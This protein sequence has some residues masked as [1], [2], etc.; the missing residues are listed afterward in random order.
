MPGYLA[1]LPFTPDRFQVE[2]VAAIE[3]GKSVVVTAP[4]GSGKTVIAEAAVQMAVD[5]GGRAFYTTPIKALSNQKFGDLSERYGTAGVGLL[6]GD[7]SI[8]GD[9]PI[10][11]MT[12]EVLRNMIHARSDALAGLRIIILDE[13]HY[14]GDRTRGAVWEEVIIHA[15]PTAQLVC[16]SATIANPRQVSDW[17]A[18]RRGGVELVVE[19]HRPVPLEA[20]YAI[21]DRWRDDRVE[22][23]PLFAGER[24]NPAVQRRLA[25]KSGNARHGGRA[26]RRFVTPRR[27]ETVEALRAQGML[28][29]IY[30]IFSRKGCEHAAGSVAATAQRKPTSQVDAIHEVVDEH[31]R[32][33]TDADLAVLDHGQWISQLERGI[34]AH[35][36][37]MVPAF[38][39]AVE[40][41]FASNLLDVV[42]ATE[43]LA[44]GI[45]MPARAVVLDSLTKFTGD[46][47]ELLTPS[48]Y[49]QLT[50]RAGRRGI[51]EVGFGVVLHSPYIRFDKV[52]DLA[53]TGAS[54]LVSSFRPTYN[55]AVNLVANYDQAR[56]EELLRASFAQYQRAG[57]E[58]REPEKVTRLRAELAALTERVECERGSTWEYLAELEG[59]GPSR[60]ALDHLRPGDVLEIPKGRR[61]G[62]YVLLKRELGPEPRLG[63]LSAGGKDATLTLRDLEEGTTVLG[64]ITWR[65]P[66]RPRDKHFRQQTVQE[67]RRFRP[68]ETRLLHP[69]PVAGSMHPVVLCPDRDAHL[70]AT[71][72]F[73]EVEAALERAGASAH[74]SLVDEFRAVLRLLEGRGYLDGWSLEPAGSRLRRVYSEQDLLVSECLREG[75]FVPCDPPELAALV[76]AFVFE[77]RAEEVRDDFPN[78]HVAEVGERMMAT[79]RGI[80]ADERSLR[81]PETRPPEFGFAG[82]AYAWSQGAD[83]DDLMDRSP[84]PAGDFVRVARQLLDLLRQVRDAE[85]GLAATAGEAL[86]SIDRGIVT[87]GGLE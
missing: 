6:T 36:A 23:L 86:R 11:V 83:L 61:P 21:K 24:P 9:A 19:E 81:L 14:L 16:L 51:D 5:G 59:G 29:A 27:G 33:L 66:F 58:G 30:F 67:L 1:D 31:L 71:R 7:N 57:R 70:A 47:H 79:W 54:T 73:R 75:L 77:P 15:P 68:R 18:S 39:E 44:V 26:P 4:T 25:E 10:V 82:L 20:M 43:T 62:R 56:A 38:K 65:G 13:V 87:T 72:R 40:T 45:N 41:L 42:F 22:L 80:V 50:G 3:S 53:G 34:A 85:P 17:I 60:E 2:A 48:E 46:T 32:F 55:M 49:T 76:S 52:V 35:H 37:G 28:P 63:V 78:A 84:I 64:S 74:G 69:G 8:N 12:T